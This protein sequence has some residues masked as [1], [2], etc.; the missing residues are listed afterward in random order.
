MPIYEMERNKLLYIQFISRI[1]IVVRL[2]NVFV[3]ARALK[4][5]K[6]YWN[7]VEFFSLMLIEWATCDTDRCRAGMS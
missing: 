2:T 3:H 1:T 7:N 4:T 6:V 5:K